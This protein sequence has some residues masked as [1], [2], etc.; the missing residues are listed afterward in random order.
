MPLKSLFMFIGKRSIDEKGLKGASSPSSSYFAQ[1]YKGDLMDKRR[2][3]LVD[4]DPG[5]IDLYEE[6]LKGIGLV[7]DVAVNG[8]EGLGFVEQKSYDVIV[9]DLN[10]PKLSGIQFITCARISKRNSS[11]PVIVLSGE[12]HNHLDRLE[13][14]SVLKSFHKSGDIEEVGAYIK[15]ILAPS[16]LRVV[17]YDSEMVQVFTRVTHE[18]FTFYLGKEN[19][20]SEPLALLTGKQETRGFSTGSI[21]IFGR[22]VFGSLSVS[23]DEDC[24]KALA[25]RLFELEPSEVDVEEFKEL[26]GELANQF[27]G[28]LK[29]ALREMDYHA[30]IGIPQFLSGYKHAIPRHVS[31]PIASIEV[32]A[33]GGKGWVEFC[34]GDP[35]QLVPAREEPDGQIL[36]YR[37]AG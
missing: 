30:I 32:H 3:L 1:L 22:K 2:A 29:R 33:G 36:L 18:V 31:N 15:Q 17:G 12:L 4:D 26:T 23:L 9:T 25:G 16:P 10:M 20:S 6:V 14:L 5:I 8:L 19:V 35:K 28:N 37:K 7:V 34:L 24:I 13:G 21:C 11:T 27:A